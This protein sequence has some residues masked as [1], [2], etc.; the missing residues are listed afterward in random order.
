MTFGQL[1]F[2]RQTDE[3]I[4]LASLDYRFKCIKKYEIILKDKL[5]KKK[6]SFYK[7]NLY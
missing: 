2:H 5:N 7:L 3:Y 1:F 6:I 4:F